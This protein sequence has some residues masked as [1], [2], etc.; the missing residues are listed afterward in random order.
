LEILAPRYCECPYGNAAKELGYV[1]PGTCLDYMYDKL[2]VQFSYAF[3][4]YVP[5]H[6]LPKAHMDNSA[7]L[8]S[9]NQNSKNKKRKTTFFTEMGAQKRS[10]TETMRPPAEGTK[11]WSCFMTFNPPH[12]EEYLATIEHWSRACLSAFSSILQLRQQ[13]TV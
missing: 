1:C 9:E 5:G 8:L 12:R 3:E 10:Q 4:I 11:E 6:P 2:N 7:S 13:V